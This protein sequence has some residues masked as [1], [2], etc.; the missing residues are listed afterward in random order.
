M[1]IG[2]VETIP[3]LLLR[4]VVDRTQRATAGK[5]LFEGVLWI[6]LAY[7]GGS[8]IEA[9]CRYGWRML[10]VRASMRAGRDLRDRFASKLFSLSASFFDRRKIGDLMSLASSDTEA[11]RMA[12]GA[13][14]VTLVDAFFYLVTIPVAMFLLA[15]ELA[16]IALAPLPLVPLFVLYNEKQVHQRFRASQD[17][18]SR[19]SAIAQ[20]ALGGVRVTKAF[21]F[22]GD[23]IRR[24]HEE[25]RHAQALALSLARAQGSFVPV[26]DLFANLGLVSMLVFGGEKV[27]DG[28]LTVGTFIAFQRYVNRIIWPLTAVGF[29]AN[30][31]QRALASSHRLLGVLRAESDTPESPTPVGFPGGWRTPGGIEFRKLSFRFPGDSTFMLKEIDLAIAPGE[32]VA[33]VGSIGSGKTALLS[34][35][36][37]L[38]PV[39]RGQLRIDGVDV[40]DWALADLRRQVAYVGQDLFLF[41]E[42]VQENLSFG[43][44]Y[45]TDG[46]GVAEATRI[47]AIHEE[48]ESLGE[49]YQTLLGERGVNLSGGQ[50]QRMTIAR[51][52]ACNPAILILDDALSSVDVQTEERI[53]AGLRQR[54]SKNTE[55]V[56]AHR[57]STVRQADRI[58]VLEGGRI[59]QVGTHAALLRERSG[60]YF[61]FHEHQKLWEE[62]EAF[63]AAT[64][65]RP[66]AR[67]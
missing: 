55:L 3:P 39:A 32:R 56:A 6:A 49:G 25:G 22:E 33:F 17:Q 41:S 43:T 9:I 34:L 52:L 24:F 64:E 42:S 26:L 37:R 59:T 28:T 19:I 47:A 58:V 27:L 5:G 12:L 46:E 62:L 8:L 35:I 13:G 11:V 15:P 65:A 38:Y 7:L 44:R 54:P 61:R 14:M 48:I 31:F 40:N 45:A 63:S 2:G 60:A 53:L 51:A 1:T 18:Q 36:P 67:S 21:A 30:F 57:I 29:A 4:E 50:K 16:W 23:Q 20:E 10:L 66:E